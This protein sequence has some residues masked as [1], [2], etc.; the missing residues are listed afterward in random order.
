M[1]MRE[2]TRF[3]ADGHSLLILTEDQQ[4]LTIAVSS[5]R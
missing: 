1:Q 2:G 4:L 3:A 5:A